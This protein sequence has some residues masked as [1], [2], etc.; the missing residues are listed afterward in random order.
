MANEPVRTITAATGQHRVEIIPLPAGG[1]RL[2]TYCWTEEWVPGYGKV[3]EYWAPVHE[4][5]TCADT[6][7]RAEELAVETLR[8]HEPPGA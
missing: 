1:F 5:L 2:Q 7:E 3:D 6:L 4:G 8:I